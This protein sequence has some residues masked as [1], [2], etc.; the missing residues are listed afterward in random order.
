[1]MIKMNKKI[2]EI[3]LPFES[4]LIIKA[5]CY[6]RKHDNLFT[7]CYFHSQLHNED[8]INKLIEFHLIMFPRHII[9]KSITKPEH[10]YTGVVDNE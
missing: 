8:E 4:Y 9:V 2:K 10:A 7:Q 5:K 1:M 3:E 6:G